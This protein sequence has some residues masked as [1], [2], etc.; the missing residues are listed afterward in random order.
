M[1]A[2]GREGFKDGIG[3][4]ARTRAAVFVVLAVIC[5]LLFTQAEAQNYSFSQVT[6][7]GNDLIEPATIVKIAGIARGETVTEAGLNDAVQRLIASGLFASADIVPSGGTLV[8]RVQENPMVNI[9]NF[10]GNRRLK[11]EDLAGIVKSQARRVY[12]ASPGRGRCC[13]DHPGLCRFRP[14]RRAGRAADHRPWQQPRR[15]GLRDPRRQGDRGRAAELHRQPRLFRPSSAPG[16]RNQT[17]RIAAQHH[18]ARHLRRRP[19]RV[20]Q[21]APDRLLPCARLHRL[22][23]PLACPANSRANATGS[24]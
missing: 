18:P 21:A 5:G 10:E 14:P 22:P 11:D 19:D 16:A 15:S 23:G 7:E 20:R 4:T 24:S 2:D 8:I 6:V 1:L 12:S 17:G 3:L 13:R 9:V